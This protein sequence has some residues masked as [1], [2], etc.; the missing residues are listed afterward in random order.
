MGRPNF[1]DKTNDVYMEQNKYWIKISSSDLVKAFL[2]SVREDSHM[3]TIEDESWDTVENYARILWQD[4]TF[5]SLAPYVWDIIECSLICLSS[6]K[7][8]W[9][10]PVTEHLWQ[11]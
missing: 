5:A 4:I 9:P 11:F 10:D 2:V 1:I 7:Q 6:P 3:L 8:V